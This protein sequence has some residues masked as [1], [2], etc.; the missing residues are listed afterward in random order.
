MS[1]QLDGKL[2]QNEQRIIE[3]YRAIY[4]ESQG[5]PFEL[6]IRNPGGKS[7]DQLMKVVPIKKSMQG[8]SND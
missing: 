1:Q 2:T 8:Y 5:R 6:V 4:Q 7:P 3:T